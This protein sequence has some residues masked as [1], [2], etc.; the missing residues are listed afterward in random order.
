MRLQMSTQCAGM[1]SV[2]HMVR[3]ICSQST[4]R[5]FE[6]LRR[7]VIDAH[8]MLAG[9]RRRAEQRVQCGQVGLRNPSTVG[10][11]AEGRDR[12]HTFSDR[13]Q[14][15][16]ELPRFL[17]ITRGVEKRRMPLQNRIASF[18][19]TAKRM[20]RG[21]VRA[22]TWGGSPRQ[23]SYSTANCAS[24]DERIAPATCRPPSASRSASRTRTRHSCI[25]AALPAS[26]SYTQPG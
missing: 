21:F 26:G 22:V 2:S 15:E 23:S 20:R 14:A 6:M 10:T 8:Y 9:S 17:G 19:P 3:P 11:R 4:G 18:A 5:G 13:T 7:R 16:H 25:A 24:V 12:P 1:R